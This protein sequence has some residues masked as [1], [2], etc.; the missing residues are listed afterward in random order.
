M[1]ILWLEKKLG[2]KLSFFFELCQT[3]NNKQWR[4]FW[5]LQLFFGSKKSKNCGNQEKFFSSLHSKIFSTQEGFGKQQIWKKTLESSNLSTKHFFARL[6]FFLFNFL[7]GLI[8]ALYDFAQFLTPHPPIVT[9]F[10]TKALIL[11][12]QNPWDPLRRCQPVEMSRK[13]C[14]TVDII[15]E[16]STIT[17][18]FFKLKCSFFVNFMASKIKTE[19]SLA[20]QEFRKMGRFSIEKNILTFFY[21]EPQ[22]SHFLLCAR[23][24]FWLF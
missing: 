19:I 5:R 3:D 17:Y 11:P 18:R 14:D 2:T 10:S 4:V 13:F 23:Y 6:I 21:R 12:S 22:L 16:F 15:P 1:P 24:V 9:L 20:P 8:N 7:V